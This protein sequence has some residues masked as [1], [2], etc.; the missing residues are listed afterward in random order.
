MSLINTASLFKIDGL[1]AVITGGGT[2]I[3]LM[4]AKALAFNGAAKVYII[5]RRADKLAE[6][7]ALHP[8]IKPLVGDIT[9]QDDLKRLAAQVQQE[10]G[11]INLLITNA[12]MTGPGLESLKQRHTLKEFV[13]HAWASPMSKLNDVYELN[14]TALLYTVLAF[15]ELLDEGNKRNTG[16]PKSQVIATASTASFLRNPRAG[17]AYTS[18]KAAVVSLIK[19]LS[20]FCVPWGI[21][22]NAI[23]A[24]LFPSDL[25]APLYNPF[26]INKNIP[27]TQEGAFSRAYQ[28]AE[29][30]GS[31]EDMAGIILYLVSRAGAFVNGSVMLLDGGKVATMPATY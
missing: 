27:I 4:M 20:T 8:S 7:A 11:Y 2:G 16:L 23:A 28:P 15:L 9:S 26:R 14:C 19:S 6:A 3:G 12:G 21:R 17:F 18:S 13:E 5:G 31:E 10:S 30:A 25:A 24:G 1:V 29:R 22:F